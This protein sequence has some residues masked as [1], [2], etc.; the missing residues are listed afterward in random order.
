LSG[1]FKKVDLSKRPVD[2]CILVIKLMGTF[3]KIC[4]HPSLFFFRV[5]FS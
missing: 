2:I 4:M 1:M 5:T 3:Y